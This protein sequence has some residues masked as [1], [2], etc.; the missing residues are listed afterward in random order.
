MA[1]QNMYLIPP[2]VT[3]LRNLKNKLTK[4]TVSTVRFTVQAESIYFNQ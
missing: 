3:G 1:I 2:E 4:T